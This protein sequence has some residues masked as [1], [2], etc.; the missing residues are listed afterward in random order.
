MMSTIFETQK[1][2]WK[3][4]LQLQAQLDSLSLRMINKIDG[5]TPR[6]I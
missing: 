6:T 1:I 5:E 2:N 4:G 3:A